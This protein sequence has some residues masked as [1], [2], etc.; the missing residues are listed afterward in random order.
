MFSNPP[1][2]WDTELS[3][4]A[5]GID[6]GDIPARQAV[7]ELIKLVSNPSDNLKIL[8]MHLAMHARLAE[9]HL[10]FATR[11]YPDHKEEGLT[12]NEWSFDSVLSYTKKVCAK[13]G[14]IDFSSPFL[15]TVSDRDYETILTLVKNANLSKIKTNLLDE[16]PLPHLTLTAEENF[17]D[18]G[19][20]FP[21][22][23]HRPR[24]FSLG[25]LKDIVIDV[26]EKFGKSP[27]KHLLT[28][29]WHGGKAVTLN[30]GKRDSTLGA[31][32]KKEAVRLLYANDLYNKKWTVKTKS[33]TPTP[34]VQ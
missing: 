32:K 22:L 13:L 23:K 26:G 17:L 29:K 27:K 31:Q 3:S 25:A 9:I 20:E 11:E 2:K 33:S 8:D 5:E 18:V 4:W 10:A 21:L 14:V 34:V 6:L 15:D 24:M 12:A 30:N 28:L 16:I 1:S 19:D 7:R